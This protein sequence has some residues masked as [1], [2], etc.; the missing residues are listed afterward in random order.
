MRRSVLVG[1]ELVVARRAAPARSA[2]RAGSALPIVMAR[3]PPRAGCQVTARRPPRP[4]GPRGLPAAGRG[5]AHRPATAAPAVAA[6]GSRRP[7]TAAEHS[8]D[9]PADRR[10]A[11]AHRDHHGTAWR[12][13]HDGID[14]R[15][16]VA[17]SE[18][19]RLARVPLGTAA[20]LAPCSS[21]PRPPTRSGSTVW[22]GQRDRDGAPARRTGWSPRGAPRDQVPA[23]VPLTPTRGRR[24]PSTTA[25]Q[26]AREPVWC[27]ARPPGCRRASPP[28]RRARRRRRRRGRP[29]SV[30]PAG[31]A[32][33]AS[34]TSSSQHHAVARRHGDPGLAGDGRARAPASSTS[35]RVRRGTAARRRRR[36]RTA[37]CARRRPRRPAA[38]AAADA[39]S[40]PRRRAP[41]RPAT[42]VARAGPRR[43]HTTRR[44][45]GVG[46]GQRPGGETVPPPRR[47]AAASTVAS[48]QRQ[49]QPRRGPTRCVGAGRRLSLPS[50][51]VVPAARTAA[52][53]PAV[54]WPATRRAA[55]RRRAAAVGGSCA[56]TVASSALS[57]A[58]PSVRV[59]NSGGARGRAVAARATALCAPRGAGRPRS[60]K[61]RC[62]E[63]PGSGRRRRVADALT[64]GTSTP[65]LG[66]LERWSGRCPW[67]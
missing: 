27:R 48:W 5:P 49:G 9:R 33:V 24:L 10:S 53:T 65:R 35:K 59:P 50:A 37:R 63:E 31:T 30:A 52:P 2:C 22:T 32:T 43:G 23:V 3:P 61:R 17:P 51:T 45:D 57:A 21:S 28:A 42:R 7:R 58:R 16:L 4:A 6:D 62:G 55:G 14:Q 18:H 1:R 20:R 67:R 34:T 12:P 19:A 44:P 41:T 38:A 66:D 25:T 60:V 54:R 29:T 8:G 64:A 40:A 11:R 47:R 56:A 46:A 39:R 26:P 15:R 13:G 36:R